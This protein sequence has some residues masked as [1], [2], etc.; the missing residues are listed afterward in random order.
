MIWVSLCR[1]KCR[2]YLKWKIIKKCWTVNITIRYASR[3]SKIWVWSPGKVMRNRKVTMELARSVSYS[4][5]CWP[6]LVVDTEITTGKY[7]SIGMG[8]KSFV[9]ASWHRVKNDARGGEW[10]LIKEEIRHRIK[11]SKPGTYIRL[12]CHLIFQINYH[13][14]KEVHPS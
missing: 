3:K 9:N 11:P 4:W 6:I 13:A 2:V 10:R 7:L 12:I 1:T 5:V 8:R 14:R